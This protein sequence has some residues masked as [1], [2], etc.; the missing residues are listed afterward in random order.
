MEFG[1]FPIER[2]TIARTN[3]R[4]GRKAP[5]IGDILSSVRTR[6]V[7]VPVIARGCVEDGPLEIEAGRRRYF[8]ALAVAN[9]GKEGVMLPCVIA[10]AGDDADALE[11]SMI[12]NLLR[13]DPDQVTQWESFVRLVKKGR[14]VEDIAATFALGEVQVKRI[15]ALGNLLPRIREAFRAEDI[16]ATTAK[17][18]TLA[19]K[20][21]QKAWLDLF[22][23]PQAHVPR[24][25]QLKAW[26]FGGASISVSV[27]LFDLSAYEGQIVSDLFGEDRYFADAECFWVAQQAEIEARKN[28]YLAEGWREVMIVSEQ[29]HF[30]TW[31]HEH[32][33]K[34]KG[35]RVYID[36]HRNGEVSFHEGYLTRKEARSR[37][38][39]ECGA[40]MIA[41]PVRPELTSALQDYVD[42]HR[43][44]AVRLA[45]AAQPGVALRVMVAHAI[46]GSP[47]WR[48]KPQEQRS[49]SETV[50]ASVAA[51]PATLAFDECRRA[52]LEAI[53]FNKDASWIVMDHEPRSG[54]GA[55]VQHLLDLP[56]ETVLGVLAMV[57]AESLARGSDLIETLGVH[58]HVDMAD[59]W[60]ADEAF[61]A[62][63]RDREVLSA[64]LGEVADDGVAKAHA[65]DKGKAIKSIIGDCLTGA[66]GRTKCERWVP[67]WMAF[68]PSAYTTRGGVPTVAAANR[69]QWLAEAEAEERFDADTAQAADDD[70]PEE[71]GEAEAVDDT[72]FVDA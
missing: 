20:A 68:P 72:V 67:R 28:C 34:K 65:G 22:D 55:L 5:E 64:I 71:G 3:M 51:N 50:T 6:G 10:D 19:S 70:L 9:E 49:R 29:E 44:A 60:N 2:F 52:V 33:A 17:H 57:M 18:L 11:L 25:S 46:C 59:H 63:I 54:I 37:E 16:D 56:D 41:K 61:S 21:Q 31:E 58:L 35:G 13:Q 36:I 69:V 40:A 14:S 48:V 1:Y 53:R 7:I 27:A 24:G 47:L 8:A 66:N 38:L 45:L 32:V 12:E 30:A 39:A 15:L 62:L 42:L 43:H 23:D 4:Y 26:L